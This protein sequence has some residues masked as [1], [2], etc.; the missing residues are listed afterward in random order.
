MLNLWYS[1]DMTT[2][3]KFAVTW[4]KNYCAHG[5]EVIEANSRVEAEEIMNERIGDL[6]G[7]MQYLPDD[8][9]I[10]AFELK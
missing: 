5:E 2:K 7:S 4:A 6:Q 9:Y 10:E 3:K 1:I 8:N